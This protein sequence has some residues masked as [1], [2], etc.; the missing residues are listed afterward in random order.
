MI[1]Q[2]FPLCSVFSLPQVPHTAAMSEVRCHRRGTRSH[3]TLKS[4]RRV[5]YWLGFACD[6]E[7]WLAVSMKPASF[8]TSLNCVA[9]KFSANCARINQRF[10]SKETFL[11]FGCQ[12]KLSKKFF[13]FITLKK[14]K[15]VRV[16]VSVRS[17][18]RRPRCGGKCLCTVMK[19]IIKGTPWNITRSALEDTH[20]GPIDLKT[21]IMIQY[22]S[23]YCSSPLAQ[24]R[25]NHE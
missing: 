25:A 13:F 23:E 24:W 10:L 17:R 2:G 18:I 8:H 11:L 20:K 5:A 1:E 12:R 19:A 4:K 6:S 16:L 14:K 3:M 15:T 21:V 9:R 7:L 22:K